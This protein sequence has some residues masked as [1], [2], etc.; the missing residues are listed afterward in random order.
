MLMNAASRTAMLGCDAT[1]LYVA[2]QADYVKR[3]QEIPDFSLGSDKW[4]GMLRRKIR[5]QSPIGCD[6]GTL[7]SG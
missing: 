7:D 2:S 4:A 1:K 6:P 3:I 5:R